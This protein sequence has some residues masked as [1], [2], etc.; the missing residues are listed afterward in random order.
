[1]TESPDGVL[2]DASQF[3]TPAGVTD[4]KP[5]RPSQKK[6]RIG[7]DQYAEHL[8]YARVLV[9]TPVPHLDRLFDY[10]V[11]KEQDS[12]AVAGARVR[13][14]FGG[15][16]VNGYI[17][18]R[19]AQCDPEVTPRPLTTVFSPLPVFSSEVRSLCEAVAD[20]YAGT[21]ADVAKS[22]VVPRVAR[23]EKEPWHGPV[24]LPLA[25]PDTAR[26]AKAWEAEDPEAWLLT[27][28]LAGEAPRAVVAVT[29]GEATAEAT[30]ETSAQTTAD[31]ARHNQ[32]SDTPH[33]IEGWAVRLATAAAATLASGRGSVLVVPDARDLDAVTRALDAVVGADAYARLSA[34]DGPSARYRSFLEVVTGQRRIA[35]GTR[36]AAFAPVWNLG[37]VAMWDDHDQ[38]HVEQRAPYHHAREV[39]LLRAQHSGCAAVFASFARSSEA[40][41]LVETGWAKPLGAARPVLRDRTPWVRATSDSYESERDP[42]FHSVRLPRLAFEVARAG[43]ESGPV[44]VQVARTGFIPLLRCQRCRMPARCRQCQG[45]LQFLGANDPAPTCGWCGLIE[46]AFACEECGGRSLRAGHVGAQRTVEEFGRAFPGVPVVRATG[47]DALHHVDAKPQLV[48]ATPGAEPLV[49]GGYAAALLLDADAMLASGGL[50]SGEDVAHR[51]FAAA[52]LVRGREAGGQVVLTG[53]PSPQ[54]RAL[55]RWDPAGL[56]AREL[57]ERAE[58][59][60]PPAVRTASLSGPREAAQQ[61][62]LDIQAVDGVRA[63]GPTPVQGSSEGGVTDTAEQR[64]LLFF[65]YA[66][67]PTV[68]HALRRRK[69]LGS[70]RRDPK[71]TVRVDDPT[72]L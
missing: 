61:F 6:P 32:S 38:T 54:G 8:P 59:G 23:I 16:R 51:W 34:E 45:P 29:P 55:V 17:V 52:A 42:I 72:E 31:A 66:A 25:C 1:M 10:A 43:L 28:L 57:A 5:K 24:E 36:S 56:A 71:V 14:V 40:Q 35:V 9:D 65:D 50:R 44:L 69:A 3:R 70:L 12:D 67:G 19:V 46:R 58:V 21:V 13:V 62:C 26:W 33:H 68:T 4:T 48:I 27:E 60:L 63:V 20:R 18:E 64:W 39:L 2:F 49:D 11:L 53:H 22:A 7:A 41:R 37:L 47:A 15:R 30:A